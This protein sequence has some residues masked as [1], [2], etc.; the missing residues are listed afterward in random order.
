MLESDKRHDLDTLA[1]RHLGLKTISYDDV[2]GKGAKRIGFDQVEVA[3]AAEYAAED[4]DLTLRVHQALHPRLAAEDKLER[5]YRDIELPVTEVL[6][7]MERNGVL[8]DVELLAQQSQELGTRMMEIEAQ[9]HAAAGQPFNLNSPKQI[10]EILFEREGCRWSR[11]RPAARRRPTR[12]CWS[13][14]RWTIRCPS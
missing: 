6:F 2:T 4:A 5:L 9:A 11:R 1:A 13:S 3:R 10:Q 7:A 14:W 12:K 8:I